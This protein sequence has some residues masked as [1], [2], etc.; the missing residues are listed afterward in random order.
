MIR[1]DLDTTRQDLGRGIY[2]MIPR[3]TVTADGRKRHFVATGPS[4]S[5]QAVCASLMELGAEGQARAFRGETEIFAT[6][7]NIESMA[8]GRVSPNPPE[9][10]DNA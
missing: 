2:R 3:A 5:L 10:V 7:F 9:E 8:K 1:I 4:A 6:P